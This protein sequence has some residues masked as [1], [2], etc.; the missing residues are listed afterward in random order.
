V[1]DHKHSVMKPA[2]VLL[3]VEVCISSRDYARESGHSV[4][5]G[6]RIDSQGQGGILRR[7]PRMYIIFVQRMIIVGNTLARWQSG[8]AAACKAADI[9]SIP[10]LASISSPQNPAAI[11]FV[12]ANST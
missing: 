4:I 6:D 5:C 7:L 10:F 2:A 9:G 12:G 11:P 3:Q 8:Y 1:G